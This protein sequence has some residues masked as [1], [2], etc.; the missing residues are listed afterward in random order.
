MSYEVSSVSAGMEEVGISGDSTEGS[1]SGGC[2][3]ELLILAISVLLENSAP[4][5]VCRREGGPCSKKIPIR[6]SATS[7]AALVLT[8]G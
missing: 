1:S 5:S 6:Q 4:L 8:A 3:P 2:C 7:T